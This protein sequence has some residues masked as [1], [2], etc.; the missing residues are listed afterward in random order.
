MKQVLV[1]DIRAELKS[2]GARNF[3]IYNRSFLHGACPSK[4]QF[5]MKLNLTLYK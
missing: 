5:G 2:Y 4:K 1:P 3:T